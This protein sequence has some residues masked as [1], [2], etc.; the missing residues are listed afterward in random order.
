MVGVGEDEDVSRLQVLDLHPEKVGKLILEKGSPTA[1]KEGAWQAELA[2]LHRDG[3]EI[4]V[5]QVIL[6]HKDPTGQMQF[7]STIARDI[8]DMKEAQASIL[9]QATI[10]NGINRI[11]RETLTCE[12]A[13]ELGQS[14]LAI[15]ETLTESRFGFITE[16]NQQNRLDALALSE[17]GW[18]FCGMQPTR[19]LSHVKD[20][21]PVGLLAR[22][23]REGQAVI[24]NDPSF[25]PDWAGTLVDHSA[26][27]AYL[28]MPL[29][30]G[31]KTMGLLGLVNKEGGYTHADQEAVETL[32][33]AIVEALMHYRAEEALKG[34]E[35]KLRYLADQLLTAQENERKRLAVE[36][37]DELGHA[38]LA[39]K[40]HLSSI[41]KKLPPEQEDVKKEIRTQLDYIH[42]VIQDVRRLYHDLSPGDV[43]D[44]GLTKAL[45]TL[46]NDFAGHFPEITWQVDLVDLEGLFSLPVQTT[47]YRI[48]QEALTNIGKHANPSAVTI[49]STK[50]NHQVHFIVQ[51]NGAGFNVAQE[52]ESRSSGRGIGLVAMEERLN[53]VGG[54]FAIQSRKREGTRLSF[55][56]PAIPEEERS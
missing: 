21:Q 54:S 20:L 36:L 22:P 50:E 51:D 5:S 16:I 31:G 42:E 30:Y 35:R 43:E 29:T 14:C 45:H 33:P 44:L 49:S 46:I 9:R 23:I 37:H 28:G 11:F 13:R 10:L 55:T 38:L 40:L 19:D 24:A 25:Q 17:P 15:A 18:Q 8:S 41:E 48:M 26:L 52:I 3:R 47:I 32:A 34:S 27:T 12:T 4:P 39:L 56:I 7:F 2:L 6:A 1:I 53:M